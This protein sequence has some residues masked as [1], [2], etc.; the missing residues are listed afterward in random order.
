MRC[1]ACGQQ[2]D[3]EKVIETSLED[4]LA[5]DAYLRAKDAGEDGPIHTCPECMNE[6]YV[7]FE[8]RCA[9]CGHEIGGRNYYR[10]EAEIPISDMA[11]SDNPGLFGYC[12]NVWERM[13]RE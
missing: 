1:R 5:A 8:D 10:C 3:V 7:D 11:Y 2:P 13:S 9:V 4:A 6:A 12:A